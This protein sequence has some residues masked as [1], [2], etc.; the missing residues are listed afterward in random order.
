ML[1]NNVKVDL[2]RERERIGWYEWIDLAEDKDQLR[3]LAKKV[4]S[5]RVG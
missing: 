1:E 4:K 3:S 5:F 2:E